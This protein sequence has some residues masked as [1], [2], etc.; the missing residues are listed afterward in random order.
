M[1]NNKLQVLYLRNYHGIIPDNF[2]GII[3]HQN[4]T[5]E[6]FKEGKFHREDGP[7]CEYVSGRKG[8]YLI[9]IE[10]SDSEYLKIK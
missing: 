3:K 1:N 5:K 6:W 2:T 8:W 4:G 9:G 10:Y 7:A